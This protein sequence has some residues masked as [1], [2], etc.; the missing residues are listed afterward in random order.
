MA[1][2]R[3]SGQQVWGGA[4]KPKPGTE[5]RITMTGTAE[6]ISTLGMELMPF[7]ALVFIKYNCANAHLKPYCATNGA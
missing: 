2:T 4:S 5:L 1:P 3:C 7:D 6:S